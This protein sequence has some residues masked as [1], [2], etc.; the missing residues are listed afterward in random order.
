V[1]ATCPFVKNAQDICRGLRKEGFDVVV[2]GDKE[3][4]EVKALVGFAG[5]EA[6][7]VENLEDLR[8]LKSTSGKIGILAQTTQSRHNFH[9]LVNAI[10]K[11]YNSQAG[12]SQIRI[13]NTICQDSTTRQ[14]NALRI[15]SVCD[16]MLVIGGRN[17]A[18]SKRLANICRQNVSRTHHIEVA[19]DI[20]PS[21]VGNGDLIGVVSGAS[22]PDWI[23]KD[24]ICR[25]KDLR[26]NKK[27]LKRRRK[28]V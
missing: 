10:L 8:R 3:H 17:S 22:T 1:D 14:A 25:L 23:I 19:D 21:W 20:R 15:S 26:S 7:V 6:V 4:P 9:E 13:F 5:G 12:F 16:V 18:N 28:Q 24:V 2:I 27:S 11:R